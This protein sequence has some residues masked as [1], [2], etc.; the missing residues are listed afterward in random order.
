MSCAVIRKDYSNA[1]S[2]PCIHTHTHKL[3]HINLRK[4]KKKSHLMVVTKSQSCCISQLPQFLTLTYIPLSNVVA[5]AA[6]GAVV[7]ADACYS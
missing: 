2:H 6:A 3:A 1:H 5:A 4:T 7:A